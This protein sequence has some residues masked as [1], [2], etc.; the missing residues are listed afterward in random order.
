MFHAGGSWKRDIL[1]ANVEEFQEND[2]SEEYASRIKPKEVLVPKEGD[3][4][5]IP[6][7]DGSAKLAGTGSDVRNSSRIRQDVE[8]GEE[9]R[10]DL[11]EPDSADQQQEQDESEAKQ[12][13]RVQCFFSF[14][15]F[16]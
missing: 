10:S 12:V 2:T 4:F 9:H 14:F 1:V 15:L 7:A 13:R 3:K 16:F 11:H 6:F 8:E 5:I